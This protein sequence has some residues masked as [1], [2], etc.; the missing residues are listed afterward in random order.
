MK[1]FNLVCNLLTFHQIL[2]GT[3]IFLSKLLNDRYIPHIYLNQ[4]GKIC[5]LYISYILIF[6]KIYM[7]IEI[8]TCIVSKNCM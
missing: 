3:Y 4:N 1:V 8:T 2:L 5:N 6:I 7:Y